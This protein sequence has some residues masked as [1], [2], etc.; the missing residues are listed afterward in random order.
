M[1]IFCLVPRTPVSWVIRTLQEES[2]IR[3]RSESGE[4]APNNVEKISVHDGT[5]Y[6]GNYD[7]L[8]KTTESDWQKIFDIPGNSAFEDVVVDLNGNK[9]T[10][11]IPKIAMITQ[12]KLKSKA[13]L[14]DEFELKAVSINLENRL[15]DFKPL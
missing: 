10:L 5:V 7:G 9:A 4:N 11:L 12:L 13:Q 15:I 6:A 14:E 8:Y 1:G 2:F 3:S